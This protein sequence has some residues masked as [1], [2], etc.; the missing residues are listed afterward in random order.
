M[1]TPFP[2]SPLRSVFAAGIL[3]AA[4]LLLPASLSAQEEDPGWPRDISHDKGTITVYQPQP[5]ELTGN[6]I[7]G[8][9][10]TSFLKTGKDT[11]VFGVFW[12]SGRLDVDRDTRMA[13]LADVK[14]TRVRFPEAT[15]DQEK[16]FAQVVEA[17]IPTW[18]HP[19]SLDRL[20]ASLAAAQEEHKSTEGLRNDPPKI[21]VANAPAVLVLYDGEPVLKDIP[22]TKL[23]RVV[24]TPYPV[25]FDPATKSYYITNTTWWFGA[26]DPMGP[27]AMIK[28]PPPE[29]VAAIPREAKAQAAEDQNPDFA[30]VPPQI[31]T[32]KEPAELIWT[33]GKP[34][35]KP[36]GTGEL[37][38]VEN[39]KSEVFMEAASKAYF[40]LLSGRWY[41]SASLAGPWA[42]VRPGDLPQS[43]KNIPP[44]SPKYK[45]R[46]SVPGTEEALDALM[47]TQIP[48]TAAI[49]R[50]E[51]TDVQVSFDGEPQFKPVEGTSLEYGVN[52]GQQ[53]LKVSDQYYL[54]QQGVWYVS[55]SPKGPWTVSDKRPEGV[56]EI[57][58]SNP[59]YN[60][61]YV[62]VYQS[63]PEVVYAGYTPSYTGAYPYNGTV[64][65]GTGYYYPG[66]VGS[67]YYPWSWTWG[68]GAFYSPYYGWGYGAMGYGFAWGMA[69]GAALNH[70]GYGTGYWSGGGYYNGN[71]NAG[72]IN[73][74]NPNRPGGGQG[75]Q[76]NKPGGGQ[77]V[78]PSQLP[79]NNMYN[80]GDNAKRNATPAQRDKARQDMASSPRAAQ[81]KANNVYA[82]RDG[83]VYRQ[84]KD[85]NWQ[86]RGQGG[87]SGANIPSAGQGNR[88]SLGGG[89][90]NRPGSGAG[91]RPGMGGGQGAGARPGTMDRPGGGAGAGLNR[92]AAAR[93]RGA[94]NTSNFNR[95]GGYSGGRGG[96]YSGGRGGG[97]RSGGGRGGGRR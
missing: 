79:S 97:G 65:Y 94:A 84:G 77:G 3:L 24:N 25:I 69:W 96:G 71:I 20:L 61:K 73:I 19:I 43:F 9:A 75:G 70:W 90:G 34:A 38:Y 41:T 26:P 72:N 2:S 11:P 83:N 30:K 28:T 23:Q 12:F 88:P 17:V 31:F 21:I 35:L 45:V 15:A 60:T 44:I 76:V 64:V 8:R 68:W 74:S 93:Q 67:F 5:E 46:A 48:Q 49:A 47:D 92:D 66:W 52:T 62:Y 50:G 29:V 6:V 82:G 16:E 27:W 13:Q 86:Q 33:N 59:L 81:R 14:I 18:V 4:A 78:R 56:D 57:P 91:N 37:L 58:A 22:G 89:Q 36:I 1:R 10:A 53:V 63:T 39:T 54:C 7:T 51:A 85:G 40:V 42:F 80:R 32:S 95:G 55:A 87:W